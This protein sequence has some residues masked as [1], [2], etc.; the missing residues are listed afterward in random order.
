M[1]RNEN[2]TSS[3]Q[4]KRITVDQ[5][6]IIITI[7]TIGLKSVE[8]AN[9]TRTSE[10]NLKNGQYLE[11]WKCKMFLISGCF[12]EV[13]VGDVALPVGVAAYSRNL[14]LQGKSKGIRMGSFFYFQI[15][16]FSLKV[17]KVLGKRDK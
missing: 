4:I 9:H 14:K 16:S 17:L 13:I 8:S 1:K 2:T 11:F 15:N 12:N 3:H 5:Q 10:N 6:V 7:T